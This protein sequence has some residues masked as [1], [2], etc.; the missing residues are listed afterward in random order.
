MKKRLLIAAVCVLLS[1]TFCACTVAKAT[2][3]KDWQL[4]NDPE[5]EKQKE[6]EKQAQKEAEQELAERQEAERKAALEEQ[7]RKE[8]EKRDQREEERKEEAERK[9]KEEEERQRIEEEERKKQEE[10]DRK[11][12]EEEERKRKEA[13]EKAKPDY[14]YT[15]K[16]VN[17]TVYVT[18]V[19]SNLSLR[20]GADVSYALN[21][22]KKFASPGEK[23]NRIAVGINNTWSKIKLDNGDIVYVSS[24]YLTKEE[25]GP[26]DPS[27]PE[28]IPHIDKAGLAKIE[29]SGKSVVV[30]GL[31]ISLDT[32]KDIATLAASTEFSFVKY[33]FGGGFA[34]YRSE[35]GEKNDRIALVQQALYALGKIAKSNERMTYNGKSEFS[36]ILVRDMLKNGD[37]AIMKALETQYGKGYSAEYTASSAVKVLGEAVAYCEDGKYKAFMY[38]GLADGGYITSDGSKSTCAIVLSDDPYIFYATGNAKSTASVAQKLA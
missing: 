25:P 12:R 36:L 23:L 38:S 5:V 28:S 22:K 19:K 35:I 4:E 20:V 8:R 33:G 32:K 18:G 17:E 21:P 11:K 29:A 7:R 14:G 1:S 31:E 37:T 10:E 30:F 6:A 13:E 34:A 26:D 24:N 16:T 2:V 3:G 9:R 15:Y 27:M